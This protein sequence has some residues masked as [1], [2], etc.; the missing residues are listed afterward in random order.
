LFGSPRAWAETDL[1]VF[2]DV[3]RVGH[4][5]IDD[6]LNIDD[7][8]LAKAISIIGLLA[9]NGGALT[10]APSSLVLGK[11]PSRRVPLVR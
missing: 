8:F 9:T 10:M 3:G 5:G 2:C 11:D 6:A 1:V 7:Q 4:D